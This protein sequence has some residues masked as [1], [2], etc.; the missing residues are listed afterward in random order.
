MK[1][2]LVTGPAIATVLALALV[3]CESATAP[4]STDDAVSTEPAPPLFHHAPDHV[5]ALLERA[6]G[7]DR[8]WEMVKPRPPGLGTSR[9]QSVP[10]YVIAPLDAADPLSPAIHVPDFLTVGGRDHVVPT[11]TGN[12]GT[13]KAVAR[14]VALQVPGWFEPPF[15]ADPCA[16]PPHDDRIAWDWVDVTGPGGHPCGRVAFVFAVQLDGEACPMPLTGLD[17]VHGAIAEGLV[18][19]FEPDEGTW[20][21]SIRPV[22]ERGVG[23]TAPAAPSGCVTPGGRSAD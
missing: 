13:F 5:G 17:R 7:S 19:P 8:M 16:A 20:P 1:G 3:A 11:P 21:V 12:R 22:T 14:T 10:F 18:N 4:V 23:V 2:H 15:G 6:W 9:D